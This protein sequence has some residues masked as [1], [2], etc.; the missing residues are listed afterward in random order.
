MHALPWQGPIV[1]VVY[2]LR[3][4]IESNPSTTAAFSSLFVTSMQ[5]H[6]NCL[7]A[8]RADSGGR[9]TGSRAAAASARSAFDPL[10]IARSRRGPVDGAA[11]IPASRP[12]AIAPR[13]RAGAGDRAGRVHVR[14]GARREGT[15]A[16]ARRT[17]S[18]RRSSRAGS[19]T[20]AGTPAR[21]TR[22]QGIVRPLGAPRRRPRSPPDAPPPVRGQ[23]RRPGDDRDPVDRRRR[24]ADRRSTTVTVGAGVAQESGR[25]RT[26]RRPRSGRPHAVP[27]ARGTGRTSSSTADESITPGKIVVREHRPCSTAPVANT[28]CRA[29]IR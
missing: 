7:P 24:A 26:P 21:T 9:T 16:R 22:S 18:A 1:I 27:A 12:C 15:P 11:S 20:A 19:S 10:D 3:S 29:R 14:S 8:P 28:R 4:S 6:A 25:S 2:R 13:R 5:R 17:R 23:D